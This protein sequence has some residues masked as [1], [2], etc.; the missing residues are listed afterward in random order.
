[1][2]A[3][4]KIAEAAKAKNLLLGDRLLRTATATSLNSHFPDSTAGAAAIC[5]MTTWD[6]TG[7]DDSP[8]E[9]TQRPANLATKDAADSAIHL[10]DRLRALL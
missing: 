3:N 7:S 2:S 9:Y 4:T 1:M 5:H 8:I 6:R 10:N